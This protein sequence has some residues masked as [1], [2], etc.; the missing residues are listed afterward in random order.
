[1][2]FLNRMAITFISIIAVMSLMTVLKP[3]KEPFKLESATTI[4]LRWS[5]S[6][7]V[8]GLVV[9]TLTFALYYHFW[10]WSTPMFEGFTISGYLMGK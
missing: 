1:M 5:R 3:L 4:D 10:D 6:A 9:C 2:D 8:L 7:I